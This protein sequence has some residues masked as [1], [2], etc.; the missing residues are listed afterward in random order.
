MKQHDNVMRAKSLQLA[1][2]FYAEEQNRFYYRTFAQCTQADVTQSLR[3]SGHVHP[4]HRDV[5]KTRI[6]LV[7]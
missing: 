2:S 7:T 5:A 4:P 3:Q 6:S 1:C